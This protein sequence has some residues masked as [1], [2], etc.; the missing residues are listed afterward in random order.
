MRELKI[1]DIR[2]TSTAKSIEI[3]DHTRIDK[4][5]AQ[6][7]TT[8]RSH[9]H[10]VREELSFVKDIKVVEVNNHLE[11]IVSTSIS[12]HTSLEKIMN[13]AE[14][15]QAVSIAIL[16]AASFPLRLQGIRSD[17]NGTEAKP[18]PTAGEA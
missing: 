18:D 17:Y 7:L 5:L 15:L 11:L 14:F 13:R 10:A 2:I 3:A 8:N 12:G 1:G 4:K 6:V 9:E 16:D